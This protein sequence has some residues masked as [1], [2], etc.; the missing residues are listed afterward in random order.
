[1]IILPASN[2]SSH[3]KK[4]NDSII[5]NLYTELPNSLTK[6]FNKMELSFI[7]CDPGTGEKARQIIL[8]QWF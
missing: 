1:M 3:K 5:E 6:I 7:K 4:W 2:L 8:Y